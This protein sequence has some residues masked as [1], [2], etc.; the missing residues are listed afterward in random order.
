MSTCH[1]SF[2]KQ[3]FSYCFYILS[4]FVKVFDRKIWRVQAANLHNAARAISSPSRC[5]AVKTNI[6]FVIFDIVVKNKSNVVLRGLY[7]YRQQYRSSQWSKCC[8]PCEL[9]ANWA[10]SQ[11]ACFTLVI[12]Y[13]S[14]IHPWANSR[15]WIS[16]SE[17]ALCFSYVIKLDRAH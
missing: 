17:C 10:T 1:Y 16:Q 14:S 5:S 13:V 11:S 15:C 6:Y 3:F 7:S 12:E 4:E 9:A 2:P 8:A